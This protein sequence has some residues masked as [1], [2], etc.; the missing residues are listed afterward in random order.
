MLKAGRSS[1]V[2]VI[3]HL[4]DNAAFEKV[5]NECVVFAVFIFEICLETN[6]F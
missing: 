5:G 6:G 2:G 1:V 4:T 3:L